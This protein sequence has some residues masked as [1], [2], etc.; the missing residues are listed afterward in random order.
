M[1]NRE[2]NNEN[3]TRESIYQRETEIAWNSL[4]EV[5]TRYKYERATKTTKSERLHDWFDVC[6]FS[7]ETSYQRRCLCLFR[8]IRFNRNRQ[9]TTKRCHHYPQFI[10]SIDMAQKDST[11]SQSHHIFA[12]RSLI[13]F[14][15]CHDLFVSSFL[16]ISRQFQ[17]SSS[18]HPG[19]S[20]DE[21][22]WLCASNILSVSAIPTLWPVSSLFNGCW[23]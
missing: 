14:V 21:K 15:P 1:D 13:F 16:F 10:A 11:H 9:Q 19:Y 22:L 12:F 2:Q 4:N 6:I 23:A 18:K 17:T 7:H 5:F 8:H 3:N 20:V